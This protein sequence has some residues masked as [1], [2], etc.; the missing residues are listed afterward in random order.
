MSKKILAVLAIFGALLNGAPAAT[1][2][3]ESNVARPLRY[4]PDGTDFV[5]ENGAEFFNRP[6]YGTNTAFRV[7]AGDKP[8]FVLYLPGRGGNLRVGLKKGDA[9]K[10]L[11]DAEHITTRY[12]PGSMIY[13]IRDSML[14]D[15]SLQLTAIPTND[16]QGLVLRAELKGN[17]SDVELVYV[18]GG[19]SGQ[20]GKRGGDIGAESVPVS[21]FFQFKPEYCRNNDLIVRGNNFTLDSKPAT[22]IGLAPPG[23]QTRLADA[24]RW[25]SLSGLLAVAGRPH[26]ALAVVVNQTAL[27]PNQ[28]VFFALQRV[29]QNAD[30]ENN[31]DAPDEANDAAAAQGLKPDP[32][33]GFNAADLPKLF[34][35][36]EKHR[37]EVAEKIV[38][39]T[40]DPFIN[41][42]AAALCVAADGVW[43]SKQKAFMHGAVA[44]RMKLLGW[45]GGYSG[46]AL[47][48]HERTREHLM[49]YFPKQNTSPVP[50]NETGE[51]A[52]VP[53][54][55]SNTARLSRNEPALH[56]NGD[57]TSSHY[58]MNLLAID[59][60]FRHLLWT[61]DL[62]FARKVWPVIQRHLAWERRL[63][64]REFG[65][66]KLPLYEGYACIWASDDLFY[67]GGG[68]T[69]SSALNFYHN[70]MA[71]RV[72]K[73][74]GEDPTPYER[75]SALIAKA[76]REYLWLPNEGIFAEWK[77][78]L[79]RQSVH[80][81]PALWTFYHT[82][83]SEVPTPFEAWQMRR[84]VDTQIAHIPIEPEGAPNFLFTLPTSNWMPYTWSTNNVVMAEAAHTALA[85]WEA[86][87]PYEAS[88]L[89]EGCVLD[90]MFMGLCP[91]NVGMCTQFDMARRESQR[92]FADGVG[93]TSRALIEGLFGIKPDALAGELTVRPG[94]PFGWWE[95]ASIG[96]PDFSFEYKLESYEFKKSTERFSIEQRFK[97]PMAVKLIVPAQHVSITSVTVN[98]EET[99]WRAVEDSVNIAQIEIE[100]PAVA[101]NDV[102]IEWGRD[103]GAQVSRIESDSS[104][105]SAAFPCP[106]STNGAIEFILPGTE[107]KQ[108]LDPHNDLSNVTPKTGG[109][110]ATVTG[111]SGHYSVF[112]QMQQGIR[113]WWFPLVLNV[114]ASRPDVE[115][116][117][118]SWIETHS[119][120][121]RAEIVNLSNTFNDKVTQI[122]KNQ[123]LTPR[124]P[125][126]SLAMPRQGF[127]S[128]CH[129]TDT[130]AVDDSGLRA[131][132]DKN[133][134]RI[135]LPNG[136]PFQ[137]TGTGDA[138]N[139]AFTS[140][141]DNYPREIA[142][143][144]SGNASHIY[145]LMAGSTNSM[146][147][148]FDNGEVIVTYAD[149]STERLALRNPTTWWP[150][151]QDYFIDDYA[152]RRPEP[153]PPRV[154]LKTGKVRIFDVAEF[155][156]KGGTI[157]GGAATVLDLPLDKSKELKSLTVRALANEVVIGLMSATLVR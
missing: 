137:T 113:N 35:A 97:Q 122:F 41:A 33:A 109:F 23:S 45:R 24:T 31:L 65:S 13:E 42:A 47:G 2:N 96:H 147:S 134:G 12:R 157:A 100:C 102:I 154:D 144:L 145:L 57:L 105:G 119:L 58:D 120:S 138:K 131:A 129:P 85:L 94:L 91:G 142:A 6:L 40:P 78:L 30:G 69:H 153:I 21:E 139:I 81:N 71:A 101:R 73:L 53:P 103:I 95:H 50:P 121:G 17:V 67:N 5:I 106:V 28:P 84:Y 52:Q 29:A 86:H 77:D 27:Q 7:D 48:W 112:A 80:P 70:K 114:N 146:Q 128:W 118:T 34:D 11:F 49:N 89:F 125:F 15:G 116:T 107:F 66:D 133:N 44:W 36:A 93:A 149:D 130:F 92:D 136:I 1:P 108:V 75:E 25:S 51:P 3:L 60:L 10:W 19:V 90:S 39:D 37:R 148:Q 126:C 62:D 110:S 8:E 98:G 79:G 111:S 63:F 150:I 141:W 88:R 123:Y 87:S 14:G 104:T 155:K 54:D 20:K 16:T 61:G 124:S 38:V 43:D 26:P 140:Q 99:K 4:H 127:G 46:D 72:A 56:T 143:P 22:I 32:L 18:Y 151:D 74:I 82:V 9:S 64:R 156:G 68:A 83:D 117:S 59:I 135:V 152:F 115:P 132:A 76:M 55:D